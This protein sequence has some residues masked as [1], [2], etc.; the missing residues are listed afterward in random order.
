[1][2]SEFNQGQV[3]AGKSPTLQADDVGL[4]D[5]AIELVNESPT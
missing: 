1:M 2:S 4:S 3:S 5:L